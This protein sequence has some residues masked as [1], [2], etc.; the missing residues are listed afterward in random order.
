MLARL[1]ARALRNGAFILLFVAVFVSRPATLRAE[2]NGSCV[3]RVATEYM[4]GTCRD[5]Q[6]VCVDWCGLPNTEGTPTCENPVED[7]SEMCGGCGS[8]NNCQKRTVTCRPYIEGSPS[9]V[10][11]VLR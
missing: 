2:G 8:M 10:N 7:T 3:N 6:F 4:C 9:S 11:E 5:S 1:P